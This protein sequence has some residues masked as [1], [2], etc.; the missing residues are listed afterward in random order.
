MI[1]KKIIASLLVCAL[2]FMTA[3]PASAASQSKNSVGNGSAQALSVGYTPY[4]D[5]VTTPEE[6]E[7][8][9]RAFFAANPNLY[10][11]PGMSR[12]S[13]MCENDENMMPKG[14]DPG[15]GAINV[16][17]GDMYT[18][19]S[20]YW[21][22]EQ[23]GAKLE[24]V[25]NIVLTLFGGTAGTVISVLQD[26]LTIL[27]IT[28]KIDMS[29]YGEVKVGHSISYVNKAGEFYHNG[30]WELAV[31]T[32]ERDY[33]EHRYVV[34]SVNGQTVQ[35]AVDM[36]PRNGFDAYKVDYS[37]HFKN[38]AFISQKTYELYGIMKQTGAFGVYDERWI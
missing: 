16:S 18:V 19:G 15:E 9:E 14:A 27:G 34:V 35:K 38:D 21:D 5:S 28:G 33:F 2:V 6:Q 23:S 24:A 29:S 8:H 31:L 30:R 11:I 7:E 12:Y 20:I 32:Q 36:T 25:A 10:L 13:T 37:T 1:M 3:F 26:S 17:L 22:S 4:S